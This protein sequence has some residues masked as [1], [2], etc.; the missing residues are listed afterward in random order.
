MVSVCYEVE[1]YPRTFQDILRDLR[2]IKLVSD[3]DRAARPKPEAKRVSASLE[4]P[5]RQVVRENFE[6]GL[7][8]DPDKHKRWVALLDGNEHQLEAVQAQAR[9]VDVDLTIIV[10]LIHVAGYVWGAAKALRPDDFAERREWVMEKLTDILWGRADVAAA[11]M[12]RSAT[13][14]KLGDVER[15]P[16]D[17]CADY[18][19]KYQPY[20]R[21]DEALES[22]LP[23]TTGVVEGACRHLV[24]DRMAITGA[25]WGLGGGEAVLRLRALALTGD[26]DDY[27]EFHKARELE[28]NHL[29]R[30]EHGE[31]PALDIPRVPKPRLRLVK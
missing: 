8:R 12:R 30:Y 5:V 31:L 14:R 26:L 10:D 3:E 9:A 6:D 17:E 25:R 4:K 22:G 29:S 19:L 23:I 1:P 2:G 21:Y 7:R 16:V 28:R 20:L 27:L 24:K 15:E 11:A 18:L 13:M